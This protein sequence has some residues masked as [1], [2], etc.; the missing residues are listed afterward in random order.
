M[1][2]FYAIGSSS[3]L[4]CYHSEEREDLTIEDDTSQPPKDLALS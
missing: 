2:N 3:L 4:T 1:A